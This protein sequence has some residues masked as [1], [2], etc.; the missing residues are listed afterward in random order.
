MTKG[1]QTY[2]SLTKNALSMHNLLALLQLHVRHTRDNE[3]FVNYSYSNV[4]T[5]K[6][7]LVILS[8]KTLDKGMTRKAKKE[9]QKERE[10]EQARI[11]TNLL[12]TIKQAKCK[13]VN[14]WAR[15]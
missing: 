4:V 14:K 13:V 12:I 5:L 2:L 3:P 10:E 11:V 1:N 15:A 9:R 6:E 7:Y 8:K